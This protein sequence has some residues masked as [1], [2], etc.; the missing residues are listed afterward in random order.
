MTTTDIT[1]SLPSN[2]S[3]ADCAKNGLDTNTITNV[4]INFFIFLFDLMII[5]KIQFNYQARML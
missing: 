3:N 4:I 1:S 5:F 2:L